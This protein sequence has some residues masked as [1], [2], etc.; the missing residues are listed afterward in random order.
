MDPV[1]LELCLRSVVRS[2]ATDYGVA[3]AHIEPGGVRFAPGL[4]Y[5]TIAGTR[6]ASPVR[7]EMTYTTDLNDSNAP[8]RVGN[9]VI[10]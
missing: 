8:S 5:V 3:D 7:M 1:M 4:L 10:L 6:G 9:C 2:A